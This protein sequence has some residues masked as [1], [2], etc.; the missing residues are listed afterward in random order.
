MP[1]PA[2]GRTSRVNRVHLAS[3]IEDELIARFLRGVVGSFEAAFPGRVRAYYLVGSYAT[4]EAI[5][6]SDIDLRV[7]WKGAFEQGERERA[8]RL[9]DAY[10]SAHSF[11]I[12]LPPQCEADLLAGRS[13]PLPIT[14]GIFLYGEDIR[15]TLPLPDLRTYIR[16]VTGAAY[17]NIVVRLRHHAQIGYPLRYPDPMGTFYG[18]DIGAGT[19]HFVVTIGWAATSIIAMEARQYVARKSDWLRLYRQHIADEWTPFLE[20]VYETCRNRWAYTIPDEA[21]GRAELRAL[22]QQALGFEN[23]Y[24][25][26]YRA[27]LLEARTSD[28]AAHRLWASEGLRQFAKD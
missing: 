25:R 18:Y 8:E 26:T 22:C 24:I 9:R 21:A 23:R 1:I 7:V 4:G 20:A 5:S 13:D 27:A 12:D 17:R 15:D 6:A 2:K 14:Q 3:S 10:D 11:Q 28:D 16:M 19:Q